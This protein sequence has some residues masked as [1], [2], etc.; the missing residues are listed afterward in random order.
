MGQHQ[1][2]VP[3]ISWYPYRSKKT[4]ERQQQ[5]QQQVQVHTEQRQEQQGQEVQVQA[6]QRQEQGLRLPQRAT[7]PCWARGG[8]V[9]LSPLDARM[10][11]PAKPHDRMQGKTVPAIGTCHS[12]HSLLC[13]YVHLLR[14]LLFAHL[15]PPKRP[16]TA[17]R[18]LIRIQIPRG[19]VCLESFHQVRNALQK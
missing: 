18:G 3:S 1:S 5:Q 13:M 4:P 2:T 6:E 19:G 15:I 14:T 12:F 8:R 9:A 11:L 16:R 10:R 17:L 7:L